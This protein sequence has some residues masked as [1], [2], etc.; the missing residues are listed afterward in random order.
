MESNFFCSTTMCFP[1]IHVGI[2]SFLHRECITFKKA[3]YEIKCI[4]TS[5]L[6]PRVFFALKDLD[7]S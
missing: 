6:K 2:F 5:F 7:Q 3:V 1:H 4:E